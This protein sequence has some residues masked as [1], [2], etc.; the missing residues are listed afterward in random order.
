M[1]QKFVKIIVL[2]FAFALANLF[3]FPAANAGN[4]QGNRY[5]WVYNC[6][7]GDFEFFEYKSGKGERA[8]KLCEKH[9]RHEK[10]YK[11]ADCST[12]NQITTADGKTPE[13]D[14]DSQAKK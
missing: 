6:P 5:F 1:K 8:R 9:A 12:C 2:G 13:P 14:G 7:N 10:K 3:A 11:N 4:G